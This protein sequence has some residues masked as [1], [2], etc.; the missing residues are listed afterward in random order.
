MALIDIDSLSEHNKRYGHTRGDRVL[1]E[2]ADII[3]GNLR[4]V[5]LPLRKTLGPAVDVVRYH[6]E[7]ID[8]SE[9]Y[10]GLKGEQISLAA[11]IM[12]VVDICD[13]LATDCPYRKAMSKEKA[14]SILR[15]KAD[16]RKLDREIVMHF[17][18]MIDT[19]PSEKKDGGASI[20]SVRT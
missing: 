3:A 10:D 4:Q 5:D 18:E 12:G 9:Y 8:G 15:E 11:R 16:D 17:N 1:R 19:V 2:V 7:K 20:F 6:R 13:A 14:L